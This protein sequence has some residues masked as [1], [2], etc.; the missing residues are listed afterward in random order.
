MLRKARE[1]L[2]SKVFYTAWLVIHIAYQLQLEIRDFLRFN[3]RYASKRLLSCF[4]LY[5]PQKELADFVEEV[6]KLPKVPKHLAIS[7]IPESQESVLSMLLSKL[8]PN[9][10]HSSNINNNK[11]DDDL[12]EINFEC[13]G[14]NLQTVAKI[15][16]WASAANIP[17]I[18]LYD[19]NGIL[20]TRYKELGS[21]IQEEIIQDFWAVEKIKGAI[22]PP[23]VK[24]HNVHKTNGYTNGVNG[25][26]SRDTLHIFVFS[27]NDGKPNIVRAV[28][29]IYVDKFE[30]N[31]NNPAVPMTS[32]EKLIDENTL[33]S[34]LNRYNG[35]SS[36]IVEA[37]TEPD[38]L[39]ILGNVKS[40]L[41]F[42]P[43]HIR[44]TEIHWLPSLKR[45]EICDFL[46]SFYKYAKCQ[47]RFGK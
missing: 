9:Q 1:W 19:Y 13:D 22:E 5:S 41:G 25:T 12:N 27:R 10:L 32:E 34:Y 35:W 26:K 18:S 6:S 38:L 17:V 46:T 7:V 30:R 43:W 16:A 36:H 21:Y 28:K 3:L 37:K 2:Q 4:P 14:V 33:D 20:K 11:K 15:V 47:Q 40:T 29:D 42:L 44:L 8:W 24:F 31:S 45:V 23:V 39:L